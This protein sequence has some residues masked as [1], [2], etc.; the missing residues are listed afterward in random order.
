[1]VIGILAPIAAVF[2]YLTFRLHRQNTRIRKQLALLESRFLKNEDQLSANDS[3]EPPALPIA[4]A[5]PDLQLPDA[6]ANSNPSEPPE[7]SGTEQ[8]NENEDDHG[9]P[10]A[11][12]RI[13]RTGLKQGTPAPNFSLPR[14]DDGELSLEQYRAQKVLLVFSAPDCGPCNLLAPE[15]QKLARRTPDIQV[16]MV[17]RGDREANQLKAKEHELTFPIVLQKHWEISRRYEMFA[18]PIAY[19]IDEQGIVAADVAMGPGPIIN[20]LVSSAILS[21]LDGR[22]VSSVELTEEPQIE[23]PQS[24]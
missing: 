19:L 14:I 23:V 4:P 12:S 6:S 7:Q 15:L 13:A 16:I 10:L 3:N 18:T 11:K 17:S 24:V 22:R 9:G 2:A 20:L 1:M 21:L 8:E 5:T